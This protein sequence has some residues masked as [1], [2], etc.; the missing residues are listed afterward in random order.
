MRPTV[1]LPPLPH[2]ETGDGIRV[3]FA[4]ASDI[5]RVVQ[6]ETE[7][8][9]DAWT[10]SSF[11]HVLTDT[12]SLFAVACGDDG[13]V[14]GY[15]VAW[16]VADE[17]EIANLAVASTSRRRGIGG[18]LL[19]TA[20]DTARTRDAASVYLEVRDSNEN[21]RSLYAS[22]G[23]EQVMRRRRYYRSPTEDALVLKLD[24]RSPRT[25]APR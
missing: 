16:Y 20:L 6:L 5:D 3:R 2:R 9:S 24:L 11:E 7:A 12:R 8:F 18:M 25:H 15:V 23:F 14:H 17:G 13:L 19:D 21:A 4:T 1:R 10:R 22:R